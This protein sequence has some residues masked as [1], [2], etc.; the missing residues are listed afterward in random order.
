M[1]RNETEQLL[2]EFFVQREGEGV[3]VSIRE[4]D[5]IDEGILDSLDLVTLSVFIENRFG[6]KLDLSDTNTFEAMRR[7]DSLLELISQDDTSAAEGAPRL[8]D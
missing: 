8:A 4:V 2:A 3:L 7:F 5:L 6:R 1:S